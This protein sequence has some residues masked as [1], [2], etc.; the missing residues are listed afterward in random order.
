[1][2]F[3]TKNARQAPASVTWTAADLPN[4]LGVS[5]RNSIAVDPTHPGTAYALVSPFGAHRVYMTTN[6]GAGWADITGN[7]P[8]A[9][10]D[11]VA[12]SGD[13]STIFVGTDFGVYSSTNSG[14]T[15]AQF[16]AG[17][18]NVQ[19]TDIDVKPAQIAVATYG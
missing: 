11:S 18:P 16:G 6:F 9:P 14:G 10:V 5:T 12:V 1:D 15:W 4:A 13:G 7:L 3:V 2:L 8:N 17:L 19:V